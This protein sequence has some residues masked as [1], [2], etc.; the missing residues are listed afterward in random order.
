[1]D[2][3]LGVSMAPTTVQMV[4][5]EGENADGVT[6]DQDDF[7]TSAGQPPAPSQASDQVVA[8]ILGTR[9]SAAAGGYRLMSTGVAFSDEAEAAVLRDALARH[10]LEN[11]M[12]VSPLLAAA[13]LAQAF[14]AATGYGHAALMFVEP[15]TATLAVV[16]TAGGAIVGIQQQQVRAAG[17]VAALAEA[18]SSLQTLDTRPDGLVVIGSGVDVALITQQL[19]ATTPLPVSAPEQPRLA[20]ARGAALASAHAPLFTS[21]TAAV[22]YAQDPGTGA[23]RPG[24]AAYADYNAA[25]G[26]PGLAYS[27]VPATG[28]LPA[29]DSAILDLGA[30]A[31]RQRTRRFAWAGGAVAIFVVG[32]VALAVALGIRPHSDERPDPGGHV[33]VPSK[34]APPPTPAAPPP[35]EP[36]PPAAPA[37]ANPAP[38]PPAAPAPAPAPPPALPA[39]PPAVPIPVPKIP[40][41]DIPGPDIPGPKGPKGPKIPGLPGIPGIPGL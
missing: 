10:K 30:D 17:A 27:A 40:G 7:A 33:V 13:A 25:G 22:A 6:V 29:T 28:E 12:L 39:P 24:V 8:A 5:V 41:P 18:V 2:V 9:E 21:S 35:A 11:V 14:G 1:M 31:N 37:P 26:D 34:Q 4:L 16:N 32:V 19:A 3:V 23:V 38:A 20:L 15:E 36:A